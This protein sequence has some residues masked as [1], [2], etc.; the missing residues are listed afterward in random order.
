ML[1]IE[2]LV[3]VESLVEAGRASHVDLIHAMN[4]IQTVLTNWEMRMF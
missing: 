1:G 3:R 4:H 2:N